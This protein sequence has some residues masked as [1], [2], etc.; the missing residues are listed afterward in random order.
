ME[1]CYPRLDANIF[2]ASAVWVM[3][4]AAFRERRSP[5][6]IPSASLLPGSS[7][8]TRRRSASALSASRSATYTLAYVS[9]TARREA[10]GRRAAVLRTERA[11]ARPSR[12]WGRK[13]ALWTPPPTRARISLSAR[14]VR[15]GGGAFRHPPRTLSRP[16]DRLLCA[17]ISSSRTAACCGGERE[18][19]PPEPPPPPFACDSALLALRSM[20]C[21]CRSM[22]C[23][24]NI[25]CGMSPARGVSV[26]GGELHG[27]RH[28]T[29]HQRGR[30][31]APQSGEPPQL[32][33]SR[34]PWKRQPQP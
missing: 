16:S 7:S 3:V 10:R 27:G 30:A 9:G 31:P 2:R 8:S 4:S 5:A 1:T 25:A 19:W 18:L 13:R 20:P 14:A 17:A 29:A 26:A 11:E 15:G 24:R 33:G 22:E 21:R 32:R 28:Y 34:P 6:T 23:H 12:Y